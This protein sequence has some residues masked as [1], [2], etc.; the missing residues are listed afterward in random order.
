MRRT[1][2]ERLGIQ[3]PALPTVVLGALPDGAV[4][5]ERL[6]AMGLDVVCSGAAADTAETERWLA[7]NLAYDPDVEGVRG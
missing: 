4:W 3:L 5:A 1:E 2:L 6:G 7:P